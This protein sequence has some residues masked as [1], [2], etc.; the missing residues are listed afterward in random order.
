[1]KI[2]RVLIVLTIVN[3]MLLVVLRRTHGRPAEADNGAP[4]LRGRALEI[5][6]DQGKVRAS[7]KVQPADPQAK[8][9]NGKPYSDTVILRLVDPNGRPT[10][11]LGGSV[12]GSGLG[13][14]GETDATYIQVIAEG[15]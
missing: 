15:S 13:L 5:V 3:L 4:F 2:Q 6:D 7:I 8:K 14:G 11:K 12:D 9:A 10:V 1:M